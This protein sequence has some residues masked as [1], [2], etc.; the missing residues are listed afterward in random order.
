MSD[1][2]DA[3]LGIGEF[4]LNVLDTP[5]RFVRTGLAGKDPFAS[6]LYPSQGASGREMLESWGVLGPNEEGFDT[7]DVAGFAAD[8]ATDPLNWLGGLGIAKR[9]GKN[10]AELAGSGAKNLAVDLAEKKAAD[11]QQYVGES[12]ARNRIG[13]SAI[14]D[15]TI[16][17][18][19]ISEQLTN[20]LPP[21]TPYETLWAIEHGAPNEAA[22]AI[23]QTRG[24]QGL[25]EYPHPAI[26][27]LEGTAPLRTFGFDAFTDEGLFE[28]VEVVGFVP[29]TRRDLM[30]VANNKPLPTTLEIGA[31]E[32]THSLA[33]QYPDD[34]AKMVL[35]L[36]QQTER[37]AMVSGMG[38]N[39]RSADASSAAIL[40]MLRRPRWANTE[41]GVASAIGESVKRGAAKQRFPTVDV[42]N[43]PRDAGIEAELAALLKEKYPGTE[44]PHAVT[45]PLLD[46]LEGKMQRR[47]ALVPSGPLQEVNA[48]MRMMADMDRLSL[49]PDELAAIERGYVGPAIRSINPLLAALLGY[50]AMMAPQR[51]Y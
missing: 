5:G 45:S 44:V 1:L 21:T 6:I 20:A 38:F 10:A 49:M 33:G 2:L 29:Q 34:F 50:N 14:P 41:E 28:P 47:T 46:F 13:A 51:A 25:T 48:P 15:R 30:F 23:A 36:G 43:T 31:H 11:I 17:V 7:G 39:P 9:L 32:A 26:K 18:D 27:Q 19:S 22:E 40:A 35:G 3:L 8:L 16:D 24:L 12:A 4:G 42:L 37:D